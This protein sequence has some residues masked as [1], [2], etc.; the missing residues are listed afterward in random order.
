MDK[1]KLDKSRFSCWECIEDWDYEQ[2][3]DDELIISIKEGETNRDIADYI[4]SCQEK[5]EKYD[6]L[7]G[8]PRKH[9]YC[10]ICKELYMDFCMLH[11]MIKGSYEMR[12]E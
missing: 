5:A 10:L 11:G 7:T 6:K 8:T 3:Y 2:K 9:P 4:M 1:I 12:D